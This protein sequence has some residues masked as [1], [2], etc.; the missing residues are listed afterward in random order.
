M[1]RP[2]TL[3]W[4]FALLVGCASHQI[5]DALRG[6]DILV[7]ARDEQSLELARALRGSGYHVRTKV[8][9][10]NRPTAALIYFTFS[11]P[12]PG[13]PSWLHVRLAD[14]RS[15]VIVGTAA[16]PLDSAHTSVRARARAAVEA[17]SSP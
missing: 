11:E 8:R 7:P 16:V 12:G 13:E 17:L 5:P 6:Y 4:V 2:K 15:G 9:G 3:P 14:T 1:N 10:G